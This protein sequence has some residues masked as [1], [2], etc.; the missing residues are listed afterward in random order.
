MG[1]TFYHVDSWD[2][3]RKAEIDKKYNWEEDGQ[4][5]KV[6]KSA[7][8]GSTWYGALQVDNGESVEVTAEV[9]L[10]ALDNK[11]YFNFGY[12][13]MGETCGP[14]KAE[15]PVGILKLLTPTDSEWANQWRERCWKYHEA[16]K[17]PDALKNLPYGAEIRFK[18]GNREV[19]VV[20]RAPRY[21]FKTD[22]WQVKGEKQYWSKKRIPSEYVVVSRGEAA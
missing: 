4:S 19:E 21:Q 7:M 9:V 18:W 11:E 17:S 10:T 1:W 3:D 20:K 14:H 6:L 12:K 8:V 2:L 5:V 22:W 15:C 16:K 13:E